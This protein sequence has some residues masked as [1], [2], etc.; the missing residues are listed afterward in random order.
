[1]LAA[2]VDGEES[3]RDW[4]PDTRFERAEASLRI[5]DGV[6]RSED[7]AL[8]I[9]GIELT[10]RGELDLA[11]ERFDLRAATRFVDGVDAACAV[12]PRLERVPLPVRCSGELGGERDEWCRFDR[13][14]FQATLAELLRDEVSQRAGDELERRLER[15]IERLEE[16]LGEG[17]GR[18]LRDALRGLLN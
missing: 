16:R 10:G 13:D 11:S 15:P 7:I 8:V 6:A 3:T 17:A 5:I 12:N 4:H 9:P 18:E 2:L 1:M 14:A